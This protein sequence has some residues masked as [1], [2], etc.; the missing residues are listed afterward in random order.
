MIID[1][2][3]STIHAFVKERLPKEEQ[4]REYQ[5]NEMGVSIVPDESSEATIFFRGPNAIIEIP[6]TSGDVLY[7]KKCI[8][9]AFS[10]FEKANK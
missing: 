1:V 6:L 7:L 10:H 3:T 5:V 8:D 9:T 2:Y 4:G